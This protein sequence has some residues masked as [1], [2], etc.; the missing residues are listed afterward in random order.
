M[1]SCPPLTDAPEAK[2]HLPVSWV[3][4]SSVSVDMTATGLPLS[5][6]YQLAGS[7]PNGIQ[8]KVPVL[9]GHVIKIITD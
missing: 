9:D 8:A 5:V 6:S 1:T 7:W 3:V 2:V 4:K